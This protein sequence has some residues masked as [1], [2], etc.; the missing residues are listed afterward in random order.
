MRELFRNL[1]IQPFFNLLLIF[2]LFVPGHNL[3]LAIILLTVL[4]RLLLLPLSIKAQRAQRR[5]QL[6]QPKLE[7]IKRDHKDDRELQ[8]KATMAVY[9]E[10]GISPASSCLPVLIQLPILIGLYYA[11]IQG[12]N[13]S[14]ADLAYTWL[15]VP[16]NISR[17][18]LGI[19]LTLQDRYLLPISAGLTQYF[20]AVLTL[21]KKTANDAM[22]AMSKQMTY[23]FPFITTIFAM[24]LPAALALYWTISTLFGIGQ[25]LY[26][27]R[28]AD[29]ELKPAVATSGLSGEESRLVQATRSRGGVSLTIRKK[30]K[31]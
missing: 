13:A 30:A 12:L 4:I 26:I 23:V 31:S 18:F 29:L 15:K 3:G 25:Q 2:V 1:I 22:S 8:A 11:L 5:M 19:D 24:Q 14:S 10:E 27:N 20:L 7:V 6:L 28:L 16:E 9:K 17:N 21:P